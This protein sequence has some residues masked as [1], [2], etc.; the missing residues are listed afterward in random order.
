MSTAPKQALFEAFAG[1]AR[2]LGHAHRLELVEHMAQGERSVEALAALTGISLANASQH[3]R[4]L[5]RAGL[6]AS[7]RDG[8]YVLYR[9]TGDATVALVMA[10]RRAA[11][12]NNADVER[13][14]HGYFSN[15]DALEPVTREEL[16]ARL[17]E[18]RV[19]VLDVRAK[20]E[21]ALGHVAGAVNIPLPELQA[22]L[23]ELDPGQEIVAYCRGPYCVL[24]FEAVASLRGRG[25]KVRRLED[26]FP[27]WKAAGLPVGHA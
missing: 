12:R 24:S 6:I 16:L 2:A 5:K 13:I 4:Q 19:T 18:D 3:L 15:R 9:L 23:A 27:E 10:L 20:D 26:G 7:R 22:R 14:V 11:E 1:V 8:K 17:R 21:Y 25:F